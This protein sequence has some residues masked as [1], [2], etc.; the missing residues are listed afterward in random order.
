MVFTFNGHYK[1]QQ[2]AIYM[3]RYRMMDELAPREWT[4]ILLPEKTHPI[5]GAAGATESRPAHGRRITIIID[6]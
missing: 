3:D 6:D 5:A 1:I 4:S 2:L